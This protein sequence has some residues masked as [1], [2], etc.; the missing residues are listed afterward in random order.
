MN[1]QSFL[2]LDAYLT[3]LQDY[4]HFSVFPMLDYPWAETSPQLVALLEGIDDQQLADYLQNPDDFYSS[5]LPLLPELRLLN[6]PLFAVAD[7]TEDTQPAYPCWLSNGIKGR[8]WSQISQFSAQVTGGIPVLEWCAGKGHLGRLLAFQNNNPI[9]SVEWQ[10]SLCDAGQSLADK[11]QVPQQFQQA[12]VLIGEADSLVT[13]KQHAVSLHA[14]GDLH[15]HL[16]EQVK[17]KQ[18][19]QLTF[20]PCCYHLITDE[21]YQPLSETA[22]QSTLTLSRQDLKFSIAQQVTS[23][24]RQKRLNDIEVHW[25]LSFDCLQKELL[26][27][28]AYLT[29]PSFPKVLLNQSFKDFCQWAVDLKR[30]PFTLPDDLQPFLAQGLKR[31]KMVRRTEL[32]TQFFRRPLELWLVYDRALS[33]EEAGYHIKLSTFCDFQTTPRNLLIQAKR[34]DTE[35][36]RKADQANFI[37]F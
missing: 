4:W 29:L 1:K 34:S 22:K 19:E 37:S 33:L 10:K 31:L 23:G 35:K 7:I 11:S 2:K 13:E 32:V 12:N 27:T 14:C 25:R 3:D 8:K 16:I 24:E 5:L 30:L 21:I 20:S 15:V 36:E 9:T 6:D 18:T 26:Q 28:K 17:I